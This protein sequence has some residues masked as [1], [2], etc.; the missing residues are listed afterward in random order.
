MKILGEY[1]IIRTPRLPKQQ[2]V[3][4]VVPKEVE[5]EEDAATIED[6]QESIND[7][8]DTVHE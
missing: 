8:F 6:L 2:Y 3:Y 7:K 4:V 5:E 1:S